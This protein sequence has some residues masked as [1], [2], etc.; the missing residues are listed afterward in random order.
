MKAEIEGWLRTKELEFAQKDN[1][2]PS[3]TPRKYL[4]KYVFTD[5][6]KVF[7]CDFPHLLK[8]WILR[9][10]DNH[11]TNRIQ[12]L[13]W[14]PVQVEQLQQVNNKFTHTIDFWLDSIVAG[15]ITEFAVDTTKSYSAT[16]QEFLRGPHGRYIRSLY[17]YIKILL[18]NK[19]V[20]TM[21]SDS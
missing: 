7:F 19:G 9:L 3:I 12:Q 5:L 2:N 21:E 8:E 15:F 17:T 1:R 14:T 10:K 20:M 4:D 16:E 18:Y 13:D 11:V 6:H